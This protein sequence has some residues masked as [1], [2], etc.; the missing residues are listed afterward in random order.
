MSSGS[1][2]NHMSHLFVVDESALQSLR[3]AGRGF[4][5]RSLH[6]RRLQGQYLHIAI[7][8]WLFICVSLFS[9]NKKERIEKKNEI[10]RDY[11]ISA[12]CVILTFKII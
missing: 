4:S 7:I 8:P 12:R 11:Y 3:R 2:R 10:I 6:M 5:L 9:G 1:K